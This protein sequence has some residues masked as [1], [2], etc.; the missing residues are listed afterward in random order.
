M[1]PVADVTPNGTGTIQFKDGP[2]NVGGPVPV[3]VGFA[4]GG[5]FVLPAGSHSLTAEFTPADPA[6]FAPSTSNTVRFRFRGIA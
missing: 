6:T 4:F 5:F 3:A 1:I 2:T